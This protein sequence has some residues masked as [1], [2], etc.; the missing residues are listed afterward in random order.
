MYSYIVNVYEYSHTQ[1]YR[2]YEY[3]GVQSVNHV[4]VV[5]GGDLSTD[6]NYSILGM[7]IQVIAIQ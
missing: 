4:P 5:Y 6:L 7:Q 1:L 3:A 2:K